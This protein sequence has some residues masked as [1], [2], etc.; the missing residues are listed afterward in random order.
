MIT[1]YPLAYR[2]SFNLAVVIHAH[3]TDIV[4]LSHETLQ[5]MSE[6]PKEACGVIDTI[7]GVAGEWAQRHYGQVDNWVRQTRMGK[8]VGLRER[9]IV[10]PPR[11]Y[12]GRMFGQVE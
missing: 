1:R 3:S 5:R 10:K 8:L 6:I 11:G 2:S 4:R 12:L 7:K 9:Q